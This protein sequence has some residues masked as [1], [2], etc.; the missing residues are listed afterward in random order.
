MREHF[1]NLA[2]WLVALASTDILYFKP[3]GTHDHIFYSLM[4]LEAFRTL[5]QLSDCLPGKLLLGLASRNGL[6]SK[7]IQ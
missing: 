4:A 7:S 2:G 3:H 5:Q 1:Q 6:G